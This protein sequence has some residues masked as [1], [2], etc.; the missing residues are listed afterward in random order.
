MAQSSVGGDEEMNGFATVHRRF[1]DRQA[2]AEATRWQ[3]GLAAEGVAGSGLRG[4][5]MIRLAW[6]RAAAKT[7]RARLS[8]ALPLF[9]KNRSAALP[10]YGRASHHS[11][12]AIDLA[13]LLSAEVPGVNW[14]LS[15]AVLK[16]A[17]CCW[18]LLMALVFV[19]Q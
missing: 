15:P 12:L 16:D 18:A 7:R 9:V 6:S 17:D 2:L 4:R 8:R 3:L 11:L 13:P 1:T 5:A 10:S 14:P 19:P